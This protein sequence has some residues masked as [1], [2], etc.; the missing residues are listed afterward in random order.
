MTP[1][2]HLRIGNDALSQEAKAG[3]TPIEKPAPRQK[4]TKGL[5]RTKRMARGASKLKQTPLGHC[6]P[7]QKERCS[8]QVCIVCGRFFNLCEP[9]HVV[10]RGHPKMSA[11]AAD[12]VRAVV[13]L[14]PG[15]DGCHRLFDE[16]RIDLLPFLEPAWRD[17]Q[18]WAAGAV[19]LA[20]AYRSI[21]GERLDRTTQPS[22]V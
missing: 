10:P 16:D 5:T 1:S 4:A 14:C 2:P 21:T 6:T 7:E 13:P 8:N 9:S 17:S 20:T 15:T 11:I 12:D 22:E 19:G 3:V 18:E